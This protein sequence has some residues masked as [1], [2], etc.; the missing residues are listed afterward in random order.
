VLQD[1][2]RILFLQTTEP[3]GGVE[4]RLLDDRASATLAASPVG[5]RVTLRCFCEGLETNVIL[6]SCIKP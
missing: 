6:K 3:A 5:E 2:P 1:P 4:A